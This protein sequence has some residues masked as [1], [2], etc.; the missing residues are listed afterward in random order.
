M[1]SPFETYEHLK[2]T[3]C[4]YL[5]TAYKVSDRAASS[6]R[7]KK[8]RMTGVVA[9]DPFIESTPAFPTGETLTELTQQIDDLPKELYQLASFGMPVRDFPLYQHQAE[10]LRRAYSDTPNLVVATG[11]GSGKTETFLLP[12]LADI[13]REAKNWTPPTR[14]VEAGN[15]NST[16]ETWLHGRRHERRQPAVRAIILYPMNALVNDQ[17]QRLRRILGGVDSESWQR[18]EFN[19]NVIHFGMYTGDAEP[20]GHW[21]NERRRTDW[22]SYMRAV[23]NTWAALSPEHQARGSW[24]RPDS[25]EMLCRW[26]MQAAPP[27][28]LVTNYSMLEY[29]LV[30]PLEKQIF[31]T[32]KAWL[33]RPNSRLTLVVD[34]AHTYTGARGTEIAHLVRRLKERLGIRSGDGKFR[35][36][37]TSASLPATSEARESIVTFASKLF[38]EDE[39]TFWT[40]VTPPTTPAPPAEVK[41]VELKAFAKFAEEFNFLSPD[42]AIQDLATALDMEVDLTAEPAIKLYKL[43]S[44]HPLVIRARTLTTRKAVQLERIA[45]EL[46]GDAAGPDERR[47]ATAGVF[48]AGAFAREKNVPDA[49]PLISSRVHMMF[50]GLPGVWACMD[51]SCGEVGDLSA[52]GVARPVGKL[53]TEPTPWCSCGSRVLEMFTCRVCGWMCLGGIPDTTTKSLWPWDKD[54]EGGRPDFNDFEIF[55][56]EAP[57]VGQISQYRSKRTGA[58]VQADHPDA[59]PVYEVI[60][61]NVNNTPI[62]FPNSCPRCHNRRYQSREI[63]EPLRTKGSKS[64]STLVEDAFRLQP[65]AAKSQT[66]NRG[67]KSL[68]FSDSRQ[69]AA[70][71]A[72]DLEIDHNRDL[73]RQMAYRS[74][75]SCKECLGYGTI[76]S[77]PQL[78]SQEPETTNEESCPSCSGSGI[79]PEGFKPLPVA[80]LRD[81]VL[82]LAHRAKIDPTLDNVPSY[83]SQYADFFNPNEAAAEK[84]VNSYIRNEISARDFGLEPMGL[85][86]W[87]AIFP[88]SRIGRLDVL[89][90]S[91][92]DDLVEAVVRLLATEDVLLPPTLDLQDWVADVVPQWDRNILIPP[93]EGAGKNRVQ[94]NPTGR[95]KLNRYLKAVGQKLERTSRIQGADAVNTWLQGIAEPL[96]RV[97]KMLQI[98]VPDRHRVGFGI[99]I[100]RFQLEHIGEQVHV[101]DSCAYISK[102]AVLNVC[103]RCG[104]N[105]QLSSAS[106]IRNFYRRTAMFG[107]PGQAYPDPFSL[108]VFEHSAQIEKQ[109]ARRFELR[110]QDVFVDSENPDDARI[111]MLSV[112]TT[113]EMG[114]DIGNLLSVGLR[115]VPPT[116]ANYQQRAGRAG[117]RGSGVATVV[118]YAQNRNH[119][120]YYYSD[121]PRIVSD[122]PRIP[123]LYLENAVIAQRH[124]RALVL[125]YF[126]LQWGPTSSPATVRGLLSAWGSVGDFSRNNGHQE[127]GQWIRQNRVAL[128][129]CCKEVVAENYYGELPTWVTSLA[130][131]VQQKLQNQPTSAD[132]LGA[133]LEMGYLP[134]HA[135]PI[136]VV[137]L[138]TEAPPMGAAA[139]YRERGVQRDLGIALSEFAP[140]A[141]VIR[142]KRIYQVVGLYDP[143]RFGAPNYIPD[144]RFVECRD[145]RAVTSTALTAPSP[146]SCEVCGSGNLLLLPHLR[147]PGFCSEWSGSEAGGQRYKG[148]GR[149]RAGT[150]TPAQLAVGEYAADSPAST[151]PSFAPNLRVLVRLGDLHVINRGVDPQQPGFRI[152]PQ[153][154]RSLGPGVSSHT[155]PADIPPDYGTNRGPRAGTP[156]PNNQ[157]SG[158]KYILGHRFPSEVI[159][160]GVE[161]PP[162]LDADNTRPSGRAVWHSFGTLLQNAAAR[163]LQINPEELRAGVRSVRRPGD[164]IHG[165]VYLYDTLPGGAGYARDVNANL[166]TILRQAL[167]DAARCQ[168]PDCEGACYGCL[169]DY[170]NQR[171]HALLDRKLGMALLDFLLNGAEPSLPT[172]TSSILVEQVRPFIP[173]GWNEIA[174]REIAGQDVPLILR[175]ERGQALGLLP[176]HTLRAEPDANI[177]QQFLIQG[178]RCCSFTEFDLLKQPLSVVKQMGSQN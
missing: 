26:D 52:A 53:H 137:S 128:V 106:E 14:A 92:T 111:D 83:F 131:E 176:R 113:M 160:F 119:D 19:N 116:V 138:Y 90:E 96:F 97:L 62:P 18:G 94:F 144:S 165:E 76:Q 117:R 4:S 124:V 88:Q 89:T 64:F 125:Q 40:V 167:S 48:A 32:T 1:Y 72:G 166:E 155:Y 115:N 158:N 41:D 29:M 56:V 39:R 156:C 126:F 45:T 9:Q 95:G 60:R 85:A 173:D 108:K 135:F 104:G 68:T 98:V 112:T 139:N 24:P 80:R 69:D 51:Q 13:I 172:G 93:S 142:N 99:N 44:G 162:E 3:I 20:T 153:C 7:S 141:E 61:A 136:D 81:A 21:T 27:D 148:G 17:L 129:K 55:G 159:Q 57:K 73:F 5:E 8:L 74:L 75:T 174:P 154:G 114:I 42:P 67:R 58:P 178:V 120:Q 123:R 169:L 46:W 87:R 103:L 145:C 35:C 105:T 38:G 102:R 12:V 110:F 122:P 86:T 140:G 79:S 149:E 91:E 36:I 23:R 121:P 147:P 59:R 157:P 150:S 118:T 22:N 2:E 33:R 107:A 163:V 152:C 15:Y 28:V 65:P 84:H 143:F 54:L 161:L 70:M 43:L 151:K 34:E 50:R 31:E 66:S 177:Q 100:D 168:N 170:Q 11:T 63:I 134:R 82:R 130:D 164:R 133:L 6:E 101:C 30:R 109:Q 175:D 71:L 146:V 132:V 78:L 10:A 49:Q 77:P 127:M 16:Q 25:P 47:K 37:A 171:Y